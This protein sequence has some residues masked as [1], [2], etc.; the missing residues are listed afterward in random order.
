MDLKL[1]PLPVPV[2][3]PVPVLVPVP[4]MVRRFKLRRSTFREAGFEF[5][6]G[7]GF[8]AGA[9]VGLWPR[10]LAV[11]RSKGPL[12][13]D[14]DRLFREGVEE[15]EHDEAIEDTVLVLVRP[16]L[17]LLPF[18]YASA[19]HAGVR[20]VASGAGAVVIAVDWR[21]RGWG[22]GRGLG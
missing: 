13:S 22:T 18:G 6:F 21:C 3:A 11:A 9:G 2:P 14:A 8:G 10:K 5:E 1:P 20:G 16:V 12:R 15:H 17:A 7:F 19:C 4:K